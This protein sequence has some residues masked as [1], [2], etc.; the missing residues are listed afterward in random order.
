MQSPQDARGIA[1]S[2]VERGLLGFERPHTKR[3]GRR[4]G[5]VLAVEIGQRAALQQLG[6]RKAR[7]RILGR[8]PSHCQAALD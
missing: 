6:G 5:A 1:E 4:F 7:V 2:L 3:V 8:L